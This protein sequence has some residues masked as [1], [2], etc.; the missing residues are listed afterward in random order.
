MRSDTHPNVR[1]EGSLA[2]MH[3]AQIQRGEMPA[4][5]SFEASRYPLALRQEAARHWWRR[6]RLEYGSVNEFSGLL[7]ALTKLRA[8][9]EFTGALA[10]LITDEARHAELCRG[11]AE[12]LDAG[13]APEWPAH[14]AAFP[15]APNVNGAA[16]EDETIAWAA[17]VV[18][19]SCCIGE[20]VSRPMYDALATV[21]T[22]A[23]PAAVLRQILRDEHLHASFGWAALAWFLPCLSDERRE[24]VEGRLGPRLAAFERSCTGGIPLASLAGREL[25]IESGTDDAPNLG[26]LTPEQ[27][28]M[29]FYAT[30]EAEILPKFAE[31][32]FDAMGAWAGR[33][34]PSR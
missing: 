13:P 25:V 9:V 21:A 32:G 28:A 8:P 23:V 20:T 1:A 31:L 34:G 22:D 17:D 11:M 29:I 26:T 24:W 33:H 30:L 3:R 19:A 18:L 15:D 5:A 7:H 10:R 16:D 12:A 6:A 2:A 4:F 14:R 27:F